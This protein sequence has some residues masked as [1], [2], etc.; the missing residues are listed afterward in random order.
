MII[1]ADLSSNTYP[2]DGSVDVVDNEHQEKYS[3]HHEDVHEE[4]EH[5]RQRGKGI[6]RHMYD[7]LSV[8]QQVKSIKGSLRGQ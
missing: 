8:H 3:R 2:S 7:K 4:A 6:G 5:G 1:I